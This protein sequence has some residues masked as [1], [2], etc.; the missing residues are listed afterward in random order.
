[1]NRGII[2]LLECPFCHTPL[3]VGGVF[4]V[5]AK[6]NN[7]R[8]GFVRCVCDVFPIV[9]GILYLKKNEPPVLKNQIAVDLLRQ[10]QYHEALNLLFDERRRAKLPY[11]WLLSGRFKPKTIQGFLALLKVFIPES[12]AWLNH[13]AERE[14]RPTFFLSLMNLAYVQ[15]GQIVVDAGCSAG[16]FLKHL[17]QRQP[18]ARAIGVETSFSAL[19]LARKF[20][21][22]NKGSLICADLDLGL[23]FRA[24]VVDR[25]MANDTFMYLKKKHFFL[26]ESARVTG[27]QGLTFLSH[28]HSA[29]AE[30]DGQGYG[31]TSAELSKYTKE[32][33]LWSTDDEALYRSLTKLQPH[34][35]FRQKN[36]TNILRHRSVSLVMPKKSFK[37]SH[38]PDWI[39]RLMRSTNLNFLEDPQ[40]KP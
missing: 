39:A 23:P 27:R 24:G 29:L 14:H 12:K 26:T 10:G 2:N 21:L 31:L 19:Y 40:L 18:K 28:V 7:I 36:S 20:V 8:D 35:Y 15:T 34:S 13:L 17:I 3:K 16:W 38:S 9:E 1:M 6:G 30:N 22:K 11:S 25:V 4:R 32:F 37:P 5:F 33:K